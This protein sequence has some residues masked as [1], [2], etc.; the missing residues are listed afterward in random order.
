MASVNLP[1]AALLFVCAVRGLAA[2]QAPLCSQNKELEQVALRL[3]FTPDPGSQAAPLDFRFR[4]ASCRVEE[5][6]DHG[7]RI[8]PRAVRAYFDSRA[9][10]GLSVATAQGAAAS[11]VTLVQNLD[12]SYLVAGTLGDH[13]NGRLS[14]AAIDL[15]PVSIAD[16]RGNAKILH[17]AAVLRPER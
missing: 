1:F 3:Q 5:R 14:S 10:Y 15:G 11:A 7:N 9:G 2:A 16:F 12:G 13:A 8:I 4:F 17:G 6:D